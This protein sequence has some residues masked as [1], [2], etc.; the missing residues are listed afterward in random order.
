MS[1]LQKNNVQ[2]RG[3]RRGIECD[4]KIKFTISRVGELLSLEIIDGHEAFHEAVTKTIQ[5]SFLI[6]PSKELFSSNAIIYLTLSYKI[7]T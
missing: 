7:N 5:E 1:K 3:I 2:K 6:I 4:V